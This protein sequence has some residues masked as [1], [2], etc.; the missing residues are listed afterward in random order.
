MIVC[1][2]NNV[3]SATIEQAVD[4]GARNLETIRATTGAAGCCGKC[5][6]KV[7]RVL[8]AKLQQE[9]NYQP[10]LALTEAALS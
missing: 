1:I 10:D 5:Q 2:C 9:Q 4:A 8:H 7:N 6:F 3:N